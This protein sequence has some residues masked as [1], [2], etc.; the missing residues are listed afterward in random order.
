MNGYLAC[1]ILHKEQK[2][3]IV[4]LEEQVSELTKFF[5]NILNHERE[6]ND[7]NQSLEYITILEYRLKAANAEVKALNYDGSIKAFLFLLNTD[8]CTSIDKSRNVLSDL[9]GGQLNI[10]KGMINKR[11]CAFGT[12]CK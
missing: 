2:E 7:M 6:A 5:K 10:S 3:M 11:G 1:I 4:I 12:I 8:C 9:T